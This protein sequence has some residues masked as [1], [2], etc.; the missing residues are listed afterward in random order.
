MNSIFE[1]LKGFIEIFKIII[2]RILKK[3]NDFILNKLHKNY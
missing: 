2:Y 1:K 3:E